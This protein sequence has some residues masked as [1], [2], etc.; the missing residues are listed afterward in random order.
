MV[1]LSMAEVL[2]TAALPTTEVLP[3]EMMAVLPSAAG[4][5]PVANRRCYQRQSGE[6]LLQGAGGD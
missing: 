6:L 4:D 2:Q 3:W 1:L 5:A